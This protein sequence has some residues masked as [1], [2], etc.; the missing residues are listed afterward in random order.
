VRIRESAWLSKAVDR[1][2]EALAIGPGVNVL[3]AWATARGHLRVLGE[4]SAISGDE[5]SKFLSGATTLDEVPDRAEA[6]RMERIG[7]SSGYPEPPSGT[8]RQGSEI[9]HWLEAN[10]ALAPIDQHAVALDPS[11]RFFVFKDGSVEEMMRW[12]RWWGS[13]PQATT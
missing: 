8:R 13:W 2:R 1:L 10:G 3:R 4:T 7:A 5:A 6:L 12:S 11:D 9:K